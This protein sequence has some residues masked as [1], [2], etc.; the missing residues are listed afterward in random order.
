MGLREY[1]LRWEAYQLQQAQKQNDMAT[2]AWLNQQ[3]QATTGSKHPKPMF[4]RFEQFFDH[5][6]VVD[7]IR[8]QYEPTYQATSKR[9]QKRQAYELFN[10]R[11]AEYQQLKKSGKLDEL[12]KRGGRK[13]G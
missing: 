7:S 5:N 9:S 3:V 2:Q 11:I 4:K 12:R 1:H 8:K 13:N 6:A 10:K